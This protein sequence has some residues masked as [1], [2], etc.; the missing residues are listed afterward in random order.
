MSETRQQSTEDKVEQAQAAALKLA[1]A[2]DE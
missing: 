2:P 1:R